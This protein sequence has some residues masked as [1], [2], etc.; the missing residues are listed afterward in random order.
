MWTGCH[1]DQG[2]GCSRA[3]LTSAFH[4]LSFCVKIRGVVQT[5]E[6]GEAYC[7]S[8]NVRVS[9]KKQN[10]SLLHTMISELFGNM[11]RIEQTKLLAYFL[12][13]NLRF[14]FF[15]WTLLSVFVFVLFCSA[16]AILDQF[17]TSHFP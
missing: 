17:S 1:G 9:E 12:F 4:F 6:E 16:L 3:E 7:Q 11:E 2:D 13:F 8:V 15:L 14:V 10:N 5:K